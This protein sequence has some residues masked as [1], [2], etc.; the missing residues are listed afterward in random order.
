MILGGRMR[1]SVGLYWC[2]ALPWQIDQIRFYYSMG[3]EAILKMNALELFGG[4]ICK[5]MRVSADNKK[6][7]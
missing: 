7:S 3:V 2:R 1:F 6:Y 4:Q 5:S